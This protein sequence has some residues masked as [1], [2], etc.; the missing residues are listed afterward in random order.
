MAKAKTA[1]KAT[2]RTPKAKATAPVQETVTD[3]EKG[4]SLRFRSNGL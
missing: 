2:K 4:A 1:K 3:P